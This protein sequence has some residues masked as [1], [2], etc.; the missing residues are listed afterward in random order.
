MSALLEFTNRLEQPGVPLPC[1]P[2]P[3]ASWPR[4]RPTEQ[5]KPPRPVVPLQDIH[6]QRLTREVPPDFELKGLEDIYVIDNRSA[7]ADF[8]KQNRLCGLLLEAREPLNTALGESAVRTL[9][10]V[11]DDEGFDTLFCLILVSGDMNEARLALRSFDQCW[12]LARS[13]RA[14]GKLN[15]DFELI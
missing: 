1:T 15:F 8:I 11:Q 14:N 2:L 10:L 6:W 13:Q 3:I 4:Q 12:W 7:V 9:T 5:P